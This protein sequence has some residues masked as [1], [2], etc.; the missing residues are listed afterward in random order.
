MR[1]LGT[2]KGTPVFKTGLHFSQTPTQPGVTQNHHNRGAR[3]GAELSG[4]SL[5]GPGAFFWYQR[6]T[7]FPVNICFPLLENVQ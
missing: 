5:L 4:A 3:I 1:T 6:R 2:R 7:G